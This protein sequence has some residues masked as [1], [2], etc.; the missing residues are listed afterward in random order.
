MAYGN[1][2][3]F[4]QWFAVHGQV[5]IMILQVVS[6]LILSFAAAYAAYQF[7]RLVTAKVNKERRKEFTERRKF[8]EE[9]RKSEEKRTRD[10]EKAARKDSEKNRQSF[11]DDDDDIDVEQ[12][13]D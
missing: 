7:G 8:E 10:A 13:V 5:M 11:S 12:F 1:P 3:A 4:M 2:P 6:S 9:A